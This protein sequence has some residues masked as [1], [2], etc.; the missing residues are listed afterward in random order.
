MAVN[1][2]SLT[3]YQ[4]LL[5]HG[6]YPMRDFDPSRPSSRPGDRK[7][8]AVGDGGP[9]V[10]VSFHVPLSPRRTRD[11]LTPAGTEDLF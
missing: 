5:G 3:Q 11:E 9:V 6:P 1:G 2:T 8:M 7:Y 10:S 4:F